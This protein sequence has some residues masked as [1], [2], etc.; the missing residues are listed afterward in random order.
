MCILD[1]TKFIFH[2]QKCR[3]FCVKLSKSAVRI[4]AKEKQPPSCRLAFPPHR[5][6]TERNDDSFCTHAILPY[7]AVVSTC[8]ASMIHATLKEV[9][10]SLNSSYLGLE[11]LL[12]WWLIS[13]QSKF[14]IFIA[15]KTVV[16]NAVTAK[17]RCGCSSVWL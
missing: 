5:R 17:P 11:V 7:C 13:F 16:S 8:H 1:W 6:V 3:R 9:L 12:W 2:Y 10:F 14:D 4:E 15:N